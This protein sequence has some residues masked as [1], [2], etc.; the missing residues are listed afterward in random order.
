VQYINS[1]PEEEKETPAEGEKG[2]EEGKPSAA[3]TKTGSETAGK[4]EAGK[5]E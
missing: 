2:S 1:A 3:G 4:P 5:K